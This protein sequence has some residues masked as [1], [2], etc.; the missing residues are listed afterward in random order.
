MALAHA[1]IAARNGAANAVRRAAEPALRALAALHGRGD[2]PWAPPPLAPA[3]AGMPAPFFLPRADAALAEAAEDEAPAA[4]GAA[5][6][7]ERLTSLLRQAIWL[8]V[9]KRKARP[10]RGLGGKRDTSCRV[11]D[12]R[13]NVMRARCGKGCQK[14]EVSL[15]PSSRCLPR[16]R[17]STA[18]AMTR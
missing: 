11:F 8:A 5:G 16:A 1:A 10:R 13:G 18:S 3:L 2:A 15:R 14:W 6:A 4:A 17:G 9:P 12:G 7:A